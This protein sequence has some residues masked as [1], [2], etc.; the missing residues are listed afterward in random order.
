VA[1]VR[2]AQGRTLAFTT[3]DAVGTAGLWRSVDLDADGDAMDKGETLL[4]ASG[5]DG[6]TIPG[7]SGPVALRLVNQ[8]MARACPPGGILVF[9]GSDFTA[10]APDD[11]LWLG[12][13]EDAN[14]K[15]V[16]RNFLNPSALNK[17]H[18][19]VDFASGK[20]VDLDASFTGGYFSC[21]LVHLA[22]DPKG[23]KGR[24]AYYFA[25]SNSINGKTGDLNKASRKISGLVF[26]GVALPGGALHATVQPVLFYDNITQSQTSISDGIDGIA[27][28][29]GKV[30][31]IYEA[32]PRQPGILELE[33]L[34]NNQTIESGEAQQ[35]CWITTPY[36][37]V[38]SSSRGPHVTGLMALPAGRL[39]EPQGPGLEPFGAGCLAS[40][41]LLPIVWGSGSPAP[42]SGSFALNVSNGPAGGAGWLFLGLSD[43]TLPGVGSLPFDLTPY[44]LTGCSFH[45][46]IVLG[47]PVGLDAAGACRAP[48]PIPA[49]PA[50]QGTRCFVQPL[51]ADALVNPAGL[52]TANGL[53]ITVQ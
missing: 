24:D 48:L 12:F 11:C 22:V 38:Y 8:I 30:Y 36:P 31:M 14:G 49:S 16:A 50:L 19:N 15:P 29:G 51:L 34:N 40:S 5:A 45:S 39:A 17:A 3:N 42:G 37:P 21:D 13:V 28:V 23:F 47:L 33:D 26:R 9:H 7:P 35:V 6:L 52:V 18:R 43:A 20:L 4:W 10:P 27:V 25:T 32:M 53:K 41:G 44:G 46:D 1:L 2:D